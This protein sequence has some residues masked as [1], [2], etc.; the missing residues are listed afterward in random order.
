M[1]NSQAVET[2]NKQLQDSLIISFGGYSTKGAKDE[3]Q[4]AFALKTSEGLD[5]ELKGHIAVIADGV[6]SANRAA[7]A[8]QMSVCHFIEEYL[9]TPNSWSVSK[10]ASKIIAALNSWLYSRT[11]KKHL[12]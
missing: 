1:A 11:Q 10:S 9:A 8:S 4:D 7:Q 3:N 12:N 5:L 6:S 2:S